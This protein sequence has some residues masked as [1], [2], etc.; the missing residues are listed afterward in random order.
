MSQDVTTVPLG[1]V[2]VLG[3]LNVEHRW[4][5][6]MAY[7]DRLGSV[8]FSRKKGK[9]FRGIDRSVPRRRP[10]LMGKVAPPPCLQSHWLAETNQCN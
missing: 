5:E 4:L 6:P 3:L 2:S 1:S 10:E 8:S 9:M 7:L